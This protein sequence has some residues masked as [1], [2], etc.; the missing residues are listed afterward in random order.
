MEQAKE[1]VEYQVLYLFPPNC[2]DD[3]LKKNCDDD[4]PANTTLLCLCYIVSLE[5]IRGL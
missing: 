2:D 1:L 5:Q 3:T 4:L